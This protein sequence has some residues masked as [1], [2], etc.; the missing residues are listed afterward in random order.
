[1]NSTSVSSAAAS[2]GA[3][4]RSTFDLRRDQPSGP[5][6]E[7]RS[8]ILIGAS[9]SG[10]PSNPPAACAA[11]RSS[12][13]AFQSASGLRRLPTFQLRLSVRLRLASTTDL[14]AAFH[15]ISSLRLRPSFQ[16]HLPAC[17]PVCTG[18]PPSGRLPA[19]FRLAPSINRPAR[20]RTQPPTLAGCCISGLALQPPVDSR[21]RPAFLPCL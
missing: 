8:P 5:A 14:P 10:L 15:Q 21:R 11:T 4:L 16:P 6:C 7:H 1:M 12:G 18:C 9:F 17:L 19:D 3:A 2:S 20:P 13:L